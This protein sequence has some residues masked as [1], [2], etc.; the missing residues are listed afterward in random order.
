MFQVKTVFAK[1]MVLAIKCNA[2]F[3]LVTRDKPEILFIKTNSWTHNITITGTA[4][5][6]F[7]NSSV[8]WVPPKGGDN[9][10]WDPCLRL[11]SS[12]TFLSIYY[13]LYLSTGR[14]NKGECVAFRTLWGWGHLDNRICY[15]DISPPER[16]SCHLP[17]MVQDSSAWRQDYGLINLLALQLC[18]SQFSPRF[19][20]TTAASS[21]ILVG[22]V[23]LCALTIFCIA[24]RES[25]FNICL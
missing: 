10:F 14:L 22:F 24:G 17:G 21:F 12:L 23:G 2:K 13:S 4:I 5:H 1:P 3:H 15:K 16:L 7:A 6:R 20:S 8:L 18:Q 11:S 19:Q 9:Q 25:I